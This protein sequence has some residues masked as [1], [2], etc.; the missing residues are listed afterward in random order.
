[1]GGI[2]TAV[3][4]SAVIGA[5]SAAYQSDE[6]KKLAK[7]DR[8]A[9]ESA[10]VAEQERLDK[11]ELDKR[12]TEENAGQIEFGQGDGDTMSNGF[13]DFITKPSPSPLGGGAGRS[14]LGFTV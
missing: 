7:K 6:Q 4:A 5:A 13:N 12:P 14:G 9:R 2:G 3:V 10:R 1:M 8:D 11:I